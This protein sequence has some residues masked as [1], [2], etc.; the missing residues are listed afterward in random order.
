MKADHTALYIRTATQ[1]KSELKAELSEREMIVER[2]LSEEHEALR[3]LKEHKILI[4]DEIVFNNFYQE[5][6]LNHHLIQFLERIKAALFLPIYQHATLIAYIIVNRER[7][8]H[9]FF[10]NI[11]RDEMVVFGSYISNIIH[12]LQNRNLT[13]LIAQEK[14]LREELFYKHQEINQY[15]ESVRSFLRSSA[16]R[17]IGIIFYKNR[18]FTFGNQA[19]QELIGVDL[20]THFGH[21]I[22]KACKKLVEQVEHY[23]SSQQIFGTDANGNSLVLAAIPSLEHSQII[24]TV[25]YPEIAD[26]I[27]KQIDLLANPS[28]WDYLLYLE[29]T[30]SGQLINQLIPSSGSRL[31]NFKI[32][33]LKTALSKKALLVANA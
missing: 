10:S 28:E 33:L 1:Q 22:S 29:T 24:V 15:K 9:E 21:P 18:R 13:L 14:E 11:E 8:T 5:D 23:K 27:K 17:K 2:F 3:T 7:R 4:Y 32:Q 26:M 30:K 12:L 16:Q 31:L 19:A 6:A 20:N 25:Y